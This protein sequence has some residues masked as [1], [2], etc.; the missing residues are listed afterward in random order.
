MG[1]VIPWMLQADGMS[2][3]MDK[4][5]ETPVAGG[6][7][8]VARIVIGDPDIATVW[9]GIG[10]I[11]IGAAGTVLVVGPKP[12]NASG[13]RVRYFLESDIRNFG[14]CRQSGARSVLLC[15]VHWLKTES[16]IEKGVGWWRGHETVSDR[17][18]SP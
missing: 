9:I 6:R 15:R 10:K 16:V 2:D 17:R 11:R 8:L 12:D 1:F 7:I 3:F 5:M 13:A 4:S 14:P 18:G